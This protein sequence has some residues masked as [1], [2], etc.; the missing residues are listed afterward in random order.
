MEA[1]CAA[2]ETEDPV[3]VVEEPREDPKIQAER[4]YWAILNEDPADWDADPEEDAAVVTEDP[5]TPPEKKSDFIGPLHEREAAM[6]AFFEQQQQSK[7]RIL[8]RD[9]SVAD[10]PPSKVTPTRPVTKVRAKTRP[11]SR[12]RLALSALIPWTK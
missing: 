1:E 6:R 5:V 11:V 10:E 2:E 3:E 4:E 8:T 7:G 12:S 9:R